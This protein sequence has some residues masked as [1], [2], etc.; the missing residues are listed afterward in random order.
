VV[1]SGIVF[2][3]TGSDVFNL[4]FSVVWLVGI[5][6]AFNLIDNMDGLCAGVA[7]II[8]GLRF[9]LLAVRGDW[10]DA[11]L[12]V[13]IGAAYAGFLVWNYKPAKIF[14]GDCGSMFAGFSLAALTIA[15]PVAHTKAFVAGILYPV[16]TFMYP[17]FDT[18]LVSVL[19]KIAGRPIS[20]GGRDHS[21]HRL[22]MLGLSEQRVVW[23]LWLLTALGSGIGLMV[24]WTPAV[25][26]AAGAILL[27]VLLA[28]GVFLSALPVYSGLGANSLASRA[29]L[30]ARRT[31]V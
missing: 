11:N 23:T 15:T 2:H 26:A 4:V 29:R 10:N 30:L 17:I 6:N 31:S 25:M 28:F 12:C 21:S 20:H 14:M 18:M 1:G 13:L 5:T 8:A 3:A 24:H 22:V 16:L 7:I 9:S 27:I 19:R